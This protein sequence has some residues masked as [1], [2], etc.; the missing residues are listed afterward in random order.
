V[1]I[2]QGT[3]GIL[4]MNN[5]SVKEQSKLENITL[6]DATHNSIKT[7]RSTK[8]IS[9]SKEHKDTMNLV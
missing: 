3:R 8:E 7:I 9:V 2:Q 4:K 5:M 1:K 6:K